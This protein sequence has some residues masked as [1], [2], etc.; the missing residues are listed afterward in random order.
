M[1]FSQQIT[2]QW[3]QLAREFQNS[4]MTRGQYCKQKQIKIFQ[5]DYWRKQLRKPDLPVRSSTKS[6][7]PLQIKNDRAIEEPSGIL[8]R[9]GRL[10][11][12]V[13]QGFDRD[14]LAEVIRVVG[15]VC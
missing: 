6:W 5:L 11:I 15:P 2:E 14:L 7:I 12:E 4:G 8:L 3:L 10:T 1:R 9:I 13:R